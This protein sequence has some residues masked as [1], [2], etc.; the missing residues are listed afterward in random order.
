MTIE[1]Q[2]FNMQPQN[3]QSITHL[4]AVSENASASGARTQ[5]RGIDTTSRLGYSLRHE[6]A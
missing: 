3:C 5:T 4:D 1:R 6:T 2:K